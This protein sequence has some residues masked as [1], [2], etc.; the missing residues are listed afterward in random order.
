MPITILARPQKP[1]VVRSKLLT[2]YSILFFILVVLWK[3]AGGFTGIFQDGVTNFLSEINLRQYAATFQAQGYEEYAELLSLSEG[4]LV[5]ILGA[6]SLP[7]H[8]RRMLAHAA[9]LQTK[10]LAHSQAKSILVELLMCAVWLTVSISLLTTVGCF[11]V[12]RNPNVRQA[13]FDMS[14]VAALRIWY[15]YRQMERSGSLPDWA[16]RLAFSLQQVLRRASAVL[17]PP[18]TPTSSPDTSQ[19]PSFNSSRPSTQNRNT[20]Q[21][22]TE[23][24]VP[25]VAAPLMHVR[26][27]HHKSLECT[28][29]PVS[30][31][32]S[33][34][35]ALLGFVRII[36][37]SQKVTPKSR[38][39]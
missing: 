3:L 39:R 9:A 30:K 5:N 26:G 7:G 19:A 27:L 36:R 15:W 31:K 38:E 23:S 35:K 8:R 12:L 10:T 25:R 13:A 2:R 1:E 16:C 33:K 34:A 22:V 28:L 37:P 18:Q 17:T 20:A 11:L 21:A 32:R 6:D 4:D 24:C 14:S 29:T